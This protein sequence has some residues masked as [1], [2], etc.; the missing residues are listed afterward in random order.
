[1][2]EIQVLGWGTQNAPAQR[3]TKDNEIMTLLAVD[4]T[5]DGTGAAGSFVPAVQIVSDAGVEVGTFPL[6]STLT[7]GSSARVTFAPFLGESSSTST[8]GFLHWGTNVDS[9]NLGLVLTGNGVFSTTCGGNSYTVDT[10]GAANLNLRANIGNF[11]LSN[12]W[13]SITSTGSTSLNLNTIGTLNLNATV[14]AIVGTALHDS[15]V[16]VT[17]AAGTGGALSFSAD[18]GIQI[19]GGGTNGVTISAPSHGI[20][21][22]AS[23]VTVNTQNGKT[24]TVNDHLGSPILVLTG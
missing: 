2:A 1:V 16:T 19:T 24:F 17:G 7:A 18:D 8:T 15:H 11:E 23:D 4:A 10:G 3:V 5:F 12:N 6:G 9:S 20:S 22:A 21:S 14:G 13:Q